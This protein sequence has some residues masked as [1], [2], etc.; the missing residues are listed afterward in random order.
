MAV[1]PLA[2]HTSDREGTLDEEEEEEEEEAEEEEEV[3][4]EEEA[5]WWSAA[6]ITP[7]GTNW[8]VV[9]VPNHINIF[10]FIVM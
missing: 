9:K 5:L 6:L 10:Y 1:S 8:S 7:T 4:E 2:S 3:E